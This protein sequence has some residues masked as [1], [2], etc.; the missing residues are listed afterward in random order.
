VVRTQDG[1]RD[2]T[3]VDTERESQ[4]CAAQAKLKA[5]LAAK[6][7]TF[8]VRSLTEPGSRP[9]PVIRK[10]PGQAAAPVA[11]AAVPRANPA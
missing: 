8:E 11:P 1:G 4:W 10:R 2:A 5:M 6:A 9:V 7:V 3:R